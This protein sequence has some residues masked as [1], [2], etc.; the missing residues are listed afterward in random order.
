MNEKPL[1]S[2]IVP[3]YNHADFVAECLQSIFAQ[4]YDNIE[5]IVLDDGSKDNSVEILEELKKQHEFIFEHH[6]NQGLTATLNKGLNLANGQ[7]IAVIASDDTMTPQRIALQVEHMESHP[8][9]AACGGNMVGIN[10]DGSLRTKQ[11]QLAAASLSFDD[12][13]WRNKPGIPA[14]TAMIRKNLIDKVGGY[15]PD[16]GIED[17]YMWLKLSHLGYSI[18][19]LPDVLAHYRHH[20]SNMHSRHG[21]MIE[22][23]MKIYADYQDHPKYAEVVDRFL[24]GMFVKTADREKALAKSLIKQL[25]WRNKPGKKLKGLSRLLFTRS[26]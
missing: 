12:I 4:S 16:I 24:T 14:P 5:L 8:N 9:C 21:W 2:V 13:F 6:A 3:S 23:V 18:D 17:L 22:N 10:K 20:G 15:N 25:N 7:Y 1:V 11:K 19:I 26:H